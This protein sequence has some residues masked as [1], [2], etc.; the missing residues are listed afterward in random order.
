MV[1][2]SLWVHYCFEDIY[3]FLINVAKRRA[4]LWIRDILSQIRIHTTDLRIMLF[5]VVTFK[6]PTKNNFFTVFNY[7]FLN[8]HLQYSSKIKSHKDVTKQLFG[9]YRSNFLS[10]ES[11][12][13]SQKYAKE[14]LKKEMRGE[15]KAEG[16]EADVTYLSRLT[17]TGR[18]PPLSPLFCTG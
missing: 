7:Y 17:P 1:Y 18:Q 2:F 9:S 3:V 4:V 6:M 14:T 13:A 11:L 16:R 15:L 8:V 10:R 12:T 5:S